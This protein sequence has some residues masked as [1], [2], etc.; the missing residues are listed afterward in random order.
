MDLQLGSTPR[1]LGAVL[2]ALTLTACAHRERTVVRLPPG[3]HVDLS[4]LDLRRQSLVVKLEAG[5]V[6]P[7]DVA[8]EGDLVGAPPGASIPL[9]VKRTCWI[10]IDDRGLRVSADGEDFDSGPRVP[11]TFQL[12]LDLKAAGKRATLKVR[13]PT[14]ERPAAKAG[15]E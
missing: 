10:R 14:A 7:L 15:Q 11:G 1:R 8:V 12:G 13:T 5:E 4:T 3:G 2:V 6:V 9:T